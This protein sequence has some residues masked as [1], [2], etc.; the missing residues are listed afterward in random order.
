MLFFDTF[1]PETRFL[2]GAFFPMGVAS[3]IIWV[4]ILKATA[5]M[6]VRK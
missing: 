1:F 5:G 6:N 3:K 2:E 4:A